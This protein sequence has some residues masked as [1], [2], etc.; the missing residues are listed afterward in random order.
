MNVTLRE[1]GAFIACILVL[2]LLMKVHTICVLPFSFALSVLYII[3]VYLASLYIPP[4]PHGLRYQSEFHAGLNILWRFVVWASCLTL[5]EW[6]CQLV[7][8]WM[9]GVL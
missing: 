4:M 9:I 7:F 1:Y 6:G 8:L 2:S 3:V 5:V